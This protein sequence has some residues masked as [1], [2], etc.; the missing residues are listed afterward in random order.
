MMPTAYGFFAATGC[1]SALLWLE[2]H[3]RGMGLSENE[4]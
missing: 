2:R 1:A 3:R 4:F